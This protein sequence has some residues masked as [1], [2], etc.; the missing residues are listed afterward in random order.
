METGM[1]SDAI[2]RLTSEHLNHVREERGM[3]M[4]ELAAATGITLG[5]LHRQLAYTTPITFDNAMRVAE[6]LNVDLGQ[7]MH[8]AQSR[9]EKLSD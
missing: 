8:A 3:S 4:R 5:T 9:Y 6:A 7:V 1:R 2:A